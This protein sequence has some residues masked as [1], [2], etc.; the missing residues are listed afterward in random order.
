[1][2]QMGDKKGDKW[3]FAVL[4]RQAPTTTVRPQ[5]ESTAKGLKKKKKKK[6]RLKEREDRVCSYKLKCL[7]IGLFLRKHY[8]RFRN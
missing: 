3:L 8:V 7:S 4:Q 1:M 6:P 2:L 5:N